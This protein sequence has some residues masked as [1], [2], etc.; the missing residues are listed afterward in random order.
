MQA[1]QVFEILVRENSQMLLTY[2]RA[3]IGSTDLVDEI[4]Q[5]TLFTAWQKLETFDT[6]RPFGAWLRGIAKKHLLTHYR[7]SKREMLVCNE[8]ILA[9]LEQQIA[10]LEKRPGDQWQD[11]IVPLKYCLEQLP[12]KYRQAVEARY[13]QEQKPAFIKLQLSITS[14][15]L[16]K[17][18]QRAKQHLF[19]CLSSKIAIK[20]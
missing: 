5:E 9:I 16:K 17:R 4:F 14:E 8:E 20:N 1:E 10:I 11:K 2:L 18:L 19:Q 15:A 3:S 6:S 12:N 7:K 13:I